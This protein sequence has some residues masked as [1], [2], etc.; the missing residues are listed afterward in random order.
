MNRFIRNERGLTLV[1]LL[2]TLVI[3]SLVITFIASILVMIQKQYSFQSEDIHRL[4]DITIVAK[5]ITKDIR[6]ADEV[7]VNESNIP[8]QLIKDN[9]KTT[10]TLADSIV[11][12]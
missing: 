8:L 5:S 6:S 12:K 9:K 4:T 3:S 11:K 2:A 10:Y 1:E 7:I